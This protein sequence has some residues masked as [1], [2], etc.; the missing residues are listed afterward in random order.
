M[1]RNADI[2][3][4]LGR[5]EKDN[6]GNQSLVKPGRNLVINGAMQCS[7]SRRNYNLT[8]SSNI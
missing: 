1:T 4:I 5:S 2:A 6:A 7:F 3:K 8:D